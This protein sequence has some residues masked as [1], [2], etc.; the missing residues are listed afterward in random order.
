MVEYKNLKELT[1]FSMHNSLRSFLSW[2]CPRG[3]KTE[4][5]RIKGGGSDEN[6]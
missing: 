2:M 6:P 5:R 4:R 3:G 1:G